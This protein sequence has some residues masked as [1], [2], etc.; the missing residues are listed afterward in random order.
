M[1]TTE[2]EEDEDIGEDDYDVSNE[3]NKDQNHKVIQKVGVV[4][5]GKNE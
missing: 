1:T 5:S 4:S 3:E 2:K